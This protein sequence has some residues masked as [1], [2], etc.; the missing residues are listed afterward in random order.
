MDGDVEEDDVGGAGEE[1][2]DDPLHGELAV[3]VTVHGDDD[4]HRRLVVHYP[5]RRGG[6][7]L[8]GAEWPSSLHPARLHFSGEISPAFVVAA[9][10]ADRNEMDGWR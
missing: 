8:V 1:V 9:A 4:R 10:D 6:P 2:V 7:V 5:R 3:P